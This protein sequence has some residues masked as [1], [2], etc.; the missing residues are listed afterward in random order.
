MKGFDT[1]CCFGVTLAALYLKELIIL[2][3]I[4]TSICGPG[5][6]RFWEICIDLFDLEWPICQIGWSHPNGVI[7]L[8][9]YVIVLLTSVLWMDIWGGAHGD[10]WARCLSR[11]GAVKVCD[12]LHNFQ[13]GACHR[14]VMSSTL[15]A[16]T[17]ELSNLALP[18]LPGTMRSLQFKDTWWEWK[19]G[20]DCFSEKNWSSKQN[21]RNAGRLPDLTVYRP[22]NHCENEYL[23][24]PIDLPTVLIENQNTLDVMMKTDFGQFSVSELVFY[25]IDDAVCSVLQF[26]RKLLWKLVSSDATQQTTGEDKMEYA[27]CSMTQYAIIMFLY[28]DRVML[29]TSNKAGKGNEMKEWMT[30][31]KTVVGRVSVYVVLRPTAIPILKT[32]WRTHC[33]VCGSVFLTKNGIFILVMLFLQHS[34]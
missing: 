15:G 26:L 8:L 3:F 22:L 1:K 25:V 6:G 10:T 7:D 13:R 29:H 9:I 32:N 27:Q 19:E 23:T 18:T 5:P 14:S 2:W 11:R 28:L 16:V 17:S 21:F 24:W 31:R 33:S 4:S 20:N 12:P 30:G 34:S